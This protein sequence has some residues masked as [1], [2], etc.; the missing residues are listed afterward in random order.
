MRGAAMPETATP[1][2]LCLDR[3]RRRVVSGQ[4]ANEH[5]S[6]PTGIAS[7][8]VLQHR[9]T[10]SPGIARCFALGGR[11]LLPW[12]ARRIA[13]RRKA[14]RRRKRA[15][16]GHPGVETG[17]RHCARGEETS[18]TRRPQ[19]AHQG[20]HFLERTPAE[21]CRVGSQGGA[22]RRF[23][24]ASARA[25][26]PQQRVHALPGG[27][28]NWGGGMPIGGRMPGGMPGPPI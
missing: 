3:S 13:W 11:A 21:A 14:S 10:N 20:A 9:C 19:G 28:I 17:R 22:L 4:A 16:W 12:R 7:S 24:Y 8:R 5:T 25:E 6:R 23:A 1:G 18:A 26:E 2:L 27:G 15:R